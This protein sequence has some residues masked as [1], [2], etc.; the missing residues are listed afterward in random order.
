MSNP[1]KPPGHLDLIPARP[2]FKKLDRMPRNMLLTSKGSRL[3]QAY[4]GSFKRWRR[5]QATE[6]GL[7]R[8]IVSQWIDWFQYRVAWSEMPEVWDPEHLASGRAYA[9]L[10]R[11]AL[12]ASG[13]WQA[14]SPEMAVQCWGMGCDVEL[15]EYLELLGLPTE[16]GVSVPE[17]TPKPFMI[18]HEALVPKQSHRG[19]KAGATLKK[20]RVTISEIQEIAHGRGKELPFPTDEEIRARA[21]A[22]GR[23][24]VAEMVA[25]RRAQKYNPPP[26]EPVTRVRHVVSDPA[27]VHVMGPESE[28]A[29]FTLEDELEL[30]EAQN[31][32]RPKER[33]PEE[34][35]FSTLNPGE[36]PTTEQVSEKEIETAPEW[37]K[38]L[39]TRV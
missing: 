28:A 29:T 8:V 35:E 30:I 15:K 34:V 31:R 33:T 26:V 4:P 27:L 16:P 37:L 23:K 3:V 1:I 17:G 20:E 38:G 11:R 39:I 21:H 9:A 12:A 24:T 32:F 18:T 22:E 19:R 10:S 6:H 25:E 5:T 2:S 14:V 7:K 36:E 13:I